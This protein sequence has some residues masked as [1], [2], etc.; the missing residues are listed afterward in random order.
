MTHCEILII[1]AGAAGMSAAVSAWEAGCRSV[2]LLDRASRLGGIL[3]QCIHEGF[4]PEELT[5][6]AY[7]G[8]L[9][10]RLSE[11]GVRLLLGREVLSVSKEK[12]AVVSGCGELEEIAFEKLILA[13]GCR[14]RSI[15]S[16]LLGGTRPAGVFTAGQAQ[17]M[18]NLRH[19]SVGRRIVIVGSG[20]LGMIMARRFA[21]AGNTVVAVLE[22][23]EQYGGMAR[24]YH[25]CIEAYQ[26]PILYRTVLREV[27]GM[28]R[29]T[30]VTVEHVDS[31]IREMLCCDTL[32]TALGLIP[33]QT[34]VR[35]LGDP[36]WLFYAGNC[37]RVHDMAESAAA[38]GARVG[39]MAG[40]GSAG[41]VSD[42]PRSS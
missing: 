42:R 28:P 40:T 30:G 38:E 3:P 8:R 39:R 13:A 6:P 10:R 17:E 11:T 23:N 41:L 1:G 31:G 29:V 5:G 35:G 18:M 12:T 15:G 26:I 20:D 21:A 2:L 24:N 33:E 37:R 22:Q 32:V 25:R 7:A 27:H 4:G 9:Q 36:A 14:E 34:L 16:L 19:W